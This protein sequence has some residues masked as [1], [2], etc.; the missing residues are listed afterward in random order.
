MSKDDQT[1]PAHPAAR[2]L[3]ILPTDAT[4]ALAT[5][6]AFADLLFVLRADYGAVDLLERLYDDT[7]ALRA[8]ILDTTPEEQRERDADR[9]WRRLQG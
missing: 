5:A 7:A 9:A 4:T 2:P 6:D 8:A 3:R 1:M